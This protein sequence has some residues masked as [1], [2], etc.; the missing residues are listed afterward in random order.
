VNQTIIQQWRFQAGNCQ[1]EDIAR[2]ALGITVG[3]RKK[4][5]GM[6]VA[7]MVALCLAAGASLPIPRMIAAIGNIDPLP[8]LLF[9]AKL[10]LAIWHHIF[11]FNN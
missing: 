4:P 2:R 1:K 6:M 3:Y 7:D 8:N 9:E 10:L 11:C 5:S